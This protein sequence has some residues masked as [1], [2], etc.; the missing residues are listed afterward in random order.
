MSD[1]EVT[2]ESRH[3]GAARSPRQGG[4]GCAGRCL[5]LVEQGRVLAQGPQTV[6]SAEPLE[7]SPQWGRHA[8]LVRVLVE[9]PHH[10][11]LQERQGQGAAV[12]HLK[13]KDAATPGERQRRVRC[14]FTAVNL[15]ADAGRACT[16]SE[17]PPVRRSTRDGV[18][19]ALPALGPTFLHT[20]PYTRLPSLM[21]PHPQQ[22]PRPR[23][24]RNESIRSQAL[25]L[26]APSFLR[27]FEF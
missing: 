26:A 19:P 4:V 9:S 16:Q 1:G 21:N 8:G 7:H 6:E 5:T 3:T 27:T 20:G 25:I 13:A 18:Q 11:E 12:I 15:G 10:R 24:G 14:H 22:T 17:S 2:R 23:E